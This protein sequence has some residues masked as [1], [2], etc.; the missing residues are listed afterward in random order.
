MAG[1]R[2]ANQLQAGNNT[3]S[4][5]AAHPII[6]SQFDA[7]KYAMIDQMSNGAKAWAMDRL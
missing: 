5:A 2:A 1:A 6:L 7:V 4:G 3:N